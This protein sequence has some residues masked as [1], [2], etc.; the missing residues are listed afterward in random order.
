M[1]TARQLQI[2]TE[3]ELVKKDSEF[4]KSAMLAEKLNVS[5]KT[6][7]NDI[8]ALKSE[9]M[10]QGASIVSET[11]KGYKLK[12]NDKSKFHSYKVENINSHNSRFDF[13][14]QLVRVGYILKKLMEASDYIKSEEIADEMYIS[15]SR[16]NVDLKLVRNIL[17]KYKLQIVHKS[18]YGIKID[19]LEMNRRLCIV[20]EKIP[21]YQFK[22]IIGQD[23]VKNILLEDISDVVTEV[24][25]KH[26]YK[27]SDIIFQNLLL[28][29]FVSIQRI[30][31]CKYMEQ[32]MDI[33]NDNG[34]GHEIIIAEEIMKQ[35]SLKYNIK[36]NDTEIKYLAINLHGKRSYEKHDMIS[37]ETDKLV[38]DILYEIKRK[39]YLDLTYNVQLRISLALHIIPLISRLECNMQLKNM[40]LEEI[41]QSYTL[42]YDMATYAACFISNLYGVK[43]SEDEVA[44]LAAHFNLALE[45]Q[46]ESNNPKK[47]LIIGSARRGD[48]LLMKHKLQKWF[49]DI[50]SKIDMI[51]LIELKTVDLDQYD[52]VFTTFL[53][54]EDIPENAI[55]INYF[56]NEGD[57]NRIEKALNGELFSK[58]LLNYFK[59]DLFINSDKSNT[60]EEV[61]KN[62]CKLLEDK[63]GL[64]NELYNSV[65]RRES[66]GFTSFGNMI[67]IPH[68]D[69]L[70]TKETLVAIN[71]LEKPIL[72]GNE[73]VR[74]VLLIS[75]A[76]YGEKELV[77]LFDAISKLIKDKSA[78]EKI[79][80][81]PTYSN[82]IDILEGL[83]NSKF[84]QV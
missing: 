39:M 6:I 52:V 37:E 75:V 57:Y 55:K 83:L 74:I 21:M 66:L 24:L 60:H 31:S 27:I 4:I 19:G 34:F 46:V 38:E 68:T 30:D 16:I 23:N 72:W 64:N 48:T 82:F 59:D 11:N 65:I 2:L 42:A 47:I 40:M 77:S 78:V 54:N 69:S 62:M 45:Y 17:K 14:D 73:K 10:E 12:I 25:L 9:L 67:A 22:N 13:S 56:L 15:H 35:L 33:K 80:K 81:N 50:I 58:D 71:I 32:D 51:N 18:N 3:L 28:H 44:Y 20:K 7:K 63:Y 8:K 84:P 41:K 1:I 43:V 5:T 53:N 79:L 76:K 36:L 29:I 49:R 70:I 61:I 26:Q